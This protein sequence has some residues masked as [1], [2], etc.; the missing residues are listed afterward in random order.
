MPS[1]LSGLCSFLFC[2]ETDLHWGPWIHILSL[3]LLGGTGCLPREGSGSEALP[4][5]TTMR[6][7]VSVCCYLGVPRQLG[8][9][10]QPGAPSPPH[11]LSYFREGA[12]CRP[13]VVDRTSENCGCNPDVCLGVCSAGCPQEEHGVG[14]SR[15]RCKAEWRT[16]GG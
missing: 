12:S 4:S 14:V 2:S 1:Q 11:S 13:E 15:K 10:Q 6:P 3:W 9:R 7:L 5:R 16:R 8:L